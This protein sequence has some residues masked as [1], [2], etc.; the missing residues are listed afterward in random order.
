LNAL[1]YPYLAI[2]FIIPIMFNRVMNDQKMTTPIHD[3][4]IKNRLVTL[5]Y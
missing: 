2:N 4:Q 5:Y 1:I 3:T